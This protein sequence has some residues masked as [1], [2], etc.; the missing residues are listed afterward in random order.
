MGQ[1]ETSDAWFKA[2]HW[3]RRNDNQRGAN[4]GLSRREIKA[5]EEENMRPWGR[6][7][8]AQQRVINRAKA[9]KKKK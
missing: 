7:E 1:K 3:F 8:F 4:E 6:R 5:L 9:A 2:G